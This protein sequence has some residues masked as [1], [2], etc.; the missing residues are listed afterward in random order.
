[1]PTSKSLHSGLFGFGG[2]GRTCAFP[3][4]K[5]MI[6]VETFDEKARSEERP[7][8]RQWLCKPVEIWRPDQLGPS[9][10][11][12]HIFQKRKVVVP[13]VCSLAAVL[14]GVVW[15]GGWG[16]AQR[17]VVW[18]GRVATVCFHCAR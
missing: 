13:V 1:M 16:H 11:E 18:W 10:V 2:V 8:E 3:F 5:V 15:W 17:F 4:R 6:H 14:L 9:P 12:M 7:H